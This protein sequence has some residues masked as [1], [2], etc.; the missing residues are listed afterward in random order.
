MG[1]I[2]Q[3]LEKA[4]LRQQASRSKLA[5]PNVHNIPPIQAAFVAPELPYDRELCVENRILIN[6][7]RGPSN[8]AAIA[9]YRMLRTRILQRTRANNWHI[10]GLTS[11]G[12]ADGK[13]VTA[14]NLAFAIAREKNNHVFLIDLDM[15]NPKVCEYLGVSP[16]VDIKDL[17]HGSANVANVFFS[18]GIE[19]LYLAGTRTSTD[20]SSEL[21]AAGKIELLFQYIREISPDPLIIVDLPPI[22]TTDDALVM[23]PKMEGCLLVISEGRTRRDS[24]VKAL[25]VLAE[26][27]IVG[28][29]LNRSREMVTDYYSS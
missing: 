15:R 9:S 23:G 7:R 11:P 3:V 14:I 21:L 4:K 28:I 2:Q 25:E 17:F 12:A 8:A 29:I 24:T 1:K 10:I 13:T 26:F 20:N 6:D 27:N 19:Y 22:L 16:P 5:A 18:I